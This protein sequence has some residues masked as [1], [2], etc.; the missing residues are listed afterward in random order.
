[1]AL[2][3]NGIPLWRCRAR[4]GM[5]S[6]HLDFLEVFGLFLRIVEGRSL[7]LETTLV[8]LPG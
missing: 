6:R 8:W 5:P 4:E 2:R 3:A 7:R 1:V